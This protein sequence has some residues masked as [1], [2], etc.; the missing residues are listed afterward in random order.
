MLS[1]GSRLRDPAL[2][3]ATARRGSSCGGEYLVVHYLDSGDSLTPARAA[4]A[5]GRAVGGAVV[6]NR[7]SRRIR[8]LLGSQ[9]D[10][11]PQGSCV[12]VRALPAA[13]R[14][15]S[16]RLSTELDRLVPSA[17]RKYRSRTAA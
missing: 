2:I 16:D 10:A 5:V 11:L 7:V 15:R 9:V 17:V 8:H 3:R 4:V 1:A 12:V 13:S 6:R 14:A